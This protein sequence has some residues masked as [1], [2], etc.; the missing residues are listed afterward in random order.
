MWLIVK[1][2]Q[3]GITLISLVV[4]II[5]ILIIAGISITS[6]KGDEGV[7][8][9]ANSSVTSAEEESIIIKV[10]AEVYKSRLSNGEIDIT[11]LNKY[12]SK[13]PKVMY[14]GDILNDTNKFTELPVNIEVNGYRITIKE[15]G[16]VDK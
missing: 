2:N 14:R 16:S 12:L 15:D 6:F 5:V 11:K 13:I 7:F 9:K 8:D 3:S 4:T 10:Q 1:N